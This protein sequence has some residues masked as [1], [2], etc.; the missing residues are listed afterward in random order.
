VRRTYGHFSAGVEGNAFLHA[1][2]EAANEAL[3]ETLECG[4]IDR[5]ALAASAVSPE[6]FPERAVKVRPF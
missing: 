5:Q 3:N 2:L 4:I 6:G 1:D